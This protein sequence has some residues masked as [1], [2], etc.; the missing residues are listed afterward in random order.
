MDSAA[1][2]SYGWGGERRCAGAAGDET[3]RNGGG[4]GNGMAKRV[5]VAFSGGVDSAVAALLLREQGWEVAAATMAVRDGSGFGCGED[6]G[7]AK[8]AALAASIGL[9]HRVVDCSGPYREAVLEY[10]RREYL[11]GR[12]PNPCVQCNPLV[13]FA[14]LPAAA[15]AAGLE[16]D[17]FATGHYARNVFDARVGRN[18]LRRGRDTAKDQSYFLYRLT[19]EQLATTLFPLGEF[20]KAEVR[21]MARERGLTVHDQPDSQDFYAGDYADLLGAAA[22]EGDIVDAAGRILGRHR[23]YWH[24]TPGQRKGLGVA[25][26]E[27]LYVLRLEPA[28]NRVVVG[29]RA[30]SLRDGCVARDLVFNLPVPA[31]G[32]RLFGRIR[33]SQPPRELAIAGA[34]GD[35]GLAVRFLQPLSGVA[36][37]QS[38]V[39][40]DGDTVVG[41][42]VIAE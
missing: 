18:V 27:P 34:T 5:L 2:L 35:G 10:F 39:L 38:L 42:G 19:E 22:V 41:G 23:G 37:G 20:R 1:P 32:T 40:Y 9:P 24:F 26:K 12:T 33:S 28:A 17:Y 13:K 15:R 29:T 4:K 30:E 25:Y 7:P 6:A 11:A 31:P 16:F 8:A 14:A 3:L 36:P 21:V